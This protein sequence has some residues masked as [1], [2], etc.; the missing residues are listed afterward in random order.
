MEEKSK[1]EKKKV[2]PEKVKESASPK[3]FDMAAKAKL[4]LDSKM[5]EAQ[6]QEYLKSIGHGVSVEEKQSEVPFLVYVKARN[7]PIH[8]HKAMLAWP[9]AKSVSSASLKQWD[10]IFKE[11]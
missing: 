2:E 6:K 7:I 4:I 1:I 8:L 9:K 3:A 10:E 5:P 11:F